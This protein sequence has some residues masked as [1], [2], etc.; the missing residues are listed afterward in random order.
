MANVEYTHIRHSLDTTLNIFKV[1]QRKKK[2]KAS[3]NLPDRSPN[4]MSRSR[5]VFKYSIVHKDASF[6]CSQDKKFQ[7]RPL[8]WGQFLRKK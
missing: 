8:Q 2:S 7:L 3:R 6:G 4:S 1:S 5:T